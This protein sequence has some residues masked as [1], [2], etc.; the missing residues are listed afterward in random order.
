MN[1]L[2]IETKT[3]NS[4]PYIEYFLETGCDQSLVFVQHGFQSTKEKGGDYLALTLARNGHRVV[5]LDAFKHGERIAEPYISKPIALRYAEIFHVVDQTA[6]DILTIYNEKFK[7][8]YP[9]FDMIGVSM[10]GFI[11][12]S[13]ALRS[14]HVHK[15]VPTITTPMFLKLAKTRRNVKEVEEYQKHIKPHLG[16]IESI[17]VYARKESLQFHELLIL[18]GEKDPIIPIEDSVT[19]FRELVNRK[20]TMHVYDEVHSVNREMQNEIFNFISEKVTL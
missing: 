16:F 17:D 18:S 19:F 2:L 11:A 7:E 20:A 15:L 6:N 14:N 3:H 10:G 5:A 4:I 12:Y 13:V 1:R 8:N 9:L